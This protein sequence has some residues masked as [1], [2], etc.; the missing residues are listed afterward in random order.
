MSKIMIALVLTAI[1]YH[2][3][4][5]DFVKFIRDYMFARAISIANADNYN[6]QVKMFRLVNNKWSIV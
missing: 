2:Y 6:I 4:G 3:V 1:E 5:I